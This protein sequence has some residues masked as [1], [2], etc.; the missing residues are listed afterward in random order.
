[1]SKDIV[2]NPLNINKNIEEFILKKC[3]YLFEG[4]CIDEGYVKEDSIQILKKSLGSY[5]GS[6]FN[7]ATT[8]RVMFEALI[9][10][11]P[12]DS[13][14]KLN[15][16]QINKMAI[17]TIIGPLNILVVKEYETNKKLFKNLKVGDEITVRVIDKQIKKNSKYIKLSCKLV[18]QSKKKGSAL[19]VKKLKMNKEEKMIPLST[20]ED[21]PFQNLDEMDIDELVDMDIKTIDLGQS[22]LETTNAAE[23]EIVKEDEESDI[24]ELEKM[25]DKKTLGPDEVPE[26]V[27]NTTGEEDS[28]EENSDTEVEDSSE[29]ENTESEESESEA[30]SE[31]DESP[32]PDDEEEQSGGGK[33]TIKQIKMSNVDLDDFLLVNEEDDF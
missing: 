4:K 11:P 29:E 20:I 2:I 18:D 6:L 1:L 27:G 5:N 23:V 22:G 19:S 17:R 25:T 33:K 12:I 8:Y 32:E 16:E 24:L 30:E 14:I 21:F 9:C 31:D 3:K 15:I 13:V 7:G 10:N 26:F 28:S